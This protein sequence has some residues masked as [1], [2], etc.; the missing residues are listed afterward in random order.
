MVTYLVTKWLLFAG[1]LGLISKSVRLWTFVFQPLQVGD[2]NEN[3]ISQQFLW[4]LN[5]ATE[6]IRSQNRSS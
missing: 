2:C 5:W 3:N 4:P 6:N 1:N